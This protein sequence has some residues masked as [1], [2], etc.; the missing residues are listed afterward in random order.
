MYAQTT[1]GLFPDVGSS[2]FLCRMDGQLGRYLGLTSEQLKG[3][4]A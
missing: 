3:Y 4:Q 2:F 1:I